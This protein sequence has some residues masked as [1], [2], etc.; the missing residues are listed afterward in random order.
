MAVQTLEQVLSRG[1]EA[2][3]LK[4]DGQALGRYRSYYEALERGNAVMNLTAITGEEEVAR[5]HFLD[6]AALLCAVPL[7]GKRVIDVG[8]GAGF[9]GLALKIACPET[10]LMLL[11]SLDKRVVFLRSTCNSLGFSDVSCLHARAEEAVIQWREAADIV[12]SRAVASL[13]VLSELCLPYVKEGGVFIAMKGPAF[14]EELEA[15]KPAIQML[16]GKT[17][18]CRSYTIP[19]TDVTHSAILIRKAAKTPQRYPRRWA[20]IKKSP[21]S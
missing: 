6:S 3:G 4:P 16:G 13:N 14:D 7:D 2:L 10:E 5:L 15:A 21:L 12:T 18:S 9:P 11:D 17:E 1:F 19:G 20:Q 8:T